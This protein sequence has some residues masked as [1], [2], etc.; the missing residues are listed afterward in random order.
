MKLIKKVT[1]IDISK[2]SFT[3]CFGAIDE[4]LDQKISKSFIFSNDK[5][6]FRKLIKSINF[7]DVFRSEN[8][9]APL[10]FVLEA[11]GVYYE[12]LAYFLNENS[13]IVS[14]ILP[15]SLIHI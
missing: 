6:G 3:V 4:S 12:N 2:D 1:G 13:F 11:T 7:I 15:L 8:T 5:K 9:D 10:W 14:V